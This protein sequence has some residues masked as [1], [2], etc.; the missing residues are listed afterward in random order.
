MPIIFKTLIL[1]FIFNFAEAQ[2]TPLLNEPNLPR[3]QTT[4]TIPQGMRPK[5]LE[6]NREFPMALADSF[7][8]ALEYLRDSLDSKGLSATVLAKNGD[9]WNGA[10]GIS[11]LNT[12]MT[13]DMYL[14]MGSLSKSIT[15]ACLLKLQEEGLVDLDELINT[16]LP[17][18]PNITGIITIRQLLNHKSGAFDVLEHPNILDSMREDFSRIW[19]P[20]EVLNTFVNTAYFIPGAGW[21]YSNTNYILAGLIIEEVTNLSYHEAVKTKILEP[22][23][24][25]DLFLNPYE[26]ASG[27]IAHVWIFNSVFQTKVDLDALNI[28]PISIYSTAWAAGAYFSKP[29]QVAKWLNALLSGQVLSPTSLTQMKGFVEAGDIEYGLGLMKISNG[30]QSFIGHQGY[31]LY[32]SLGFFDPETQLTVVIQS[33]DATSTDLSAFLAKAYSMYYNQIVNTN[34]ITYTKGTAYPNPANDQIDLI[35]P[36]NFNTT[37]KIQLSDLLGR[38]LAAKIL[39]ENKSKISLDISE[40]PSGIYF[41]ELLN[42]KEVVVYRFL[43]E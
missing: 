42:S 24:L 25:Q 32:S 23:G 38:P 33:N 41:A 35:R 16:Y 31:I 43:V 22:I 40:L 11:H 5:N 17:A 20:D 7:Q 6:T 10:T 13:T 34:Q 28:T 9:S 21:K 15:A 39:S 36:A 1:L 8:M 3:F 4:L 26:T 18:Y 37:H 19:S 2:T 27:D 12:P 14:G 30:Q 29:E